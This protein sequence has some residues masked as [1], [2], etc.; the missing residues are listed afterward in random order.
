[1]DSKH[2]SDAYQTLRRHNS[3]IPDEVLDQ[4]KAAL[5]AHDDLVNALRAI[6]AITFDI[7]S[8]KVANAALAKAGA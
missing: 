1:V 5:L 6:A 2:I 8:R 3:S 7:D 4:M